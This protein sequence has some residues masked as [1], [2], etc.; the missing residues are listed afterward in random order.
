MPRVKRGTQVVAPSIRKAIQAL[1]KMD[2]IRRINAVREEKRAAE[3]VI[4]AD[5]K[6]IKLQEHNM[7]RQ[8]P[9]LPVEVDQALRH[10]LKGPSPGRVTRPVREQQKTIHQ[11]Y[12]T[13]Q[14][15]AAIEFGD[16]IRCHRSHVGQVI[17]NFLSNAGDELDMCREASGRKDY[18][19]RILV[20]VVGDAS[21]PEAFEWR[22][23]SGTTG[24][25]RSGWRV[26][27]APRSAARTSRSMRA[28]RAC[29]V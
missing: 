17:V 18:E 23:G 25:S 3:D 6:I 29:C 28:A 20:R 27:R 13:S 4:Q 21:A 11:R 2:Q 24:A 10:R 19:G 9:A 8:V 14:V 26:G 16:G 15:N 1:D 12:L 7:L 22:I 5:N